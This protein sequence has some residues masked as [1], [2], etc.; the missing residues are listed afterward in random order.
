MELFA[1]IGIISDKG[2]VQRPPL[3]EKMAV[4]KAKNRK[5]QEAHPDLAGQVQKIGPLREL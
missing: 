2:V 3:S 5:D 1:K 4:G